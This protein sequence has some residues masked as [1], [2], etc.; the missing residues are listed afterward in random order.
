MDKKKAA[1]V[2]SAR[3]VSPQLEKF[4]ASYFGDQFVHPDVRKGVTQALRTAGFAEGVPVSKTNVALQVAHRV[5]NKEAPVRAEARTAAVVSA[6]AACPR[7]GSAMVN[8]KLANG[9]DARYCSASKCR[10]SAWIAED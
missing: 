6:T 10:V 8:V 9:S 2:V 1:A 4:V 3:K 5:V 7:C